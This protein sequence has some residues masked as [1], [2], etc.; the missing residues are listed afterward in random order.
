MGHGRVQNL[1]HWAQSCAGLKPGFGQAARY[2]RTSVTYFGDSRRTA[3][4]YP[5]SAGPAACPLPPRAGLRRLRPVPQQLR[6]LLPLL[7]DRARHPRARALW[8]TWQKLPGPG[9][10]RG[11]DR[12]GVDLSSA[13]VDGEPVRVRGDGARDGDAF[14]CFDGPGAEG[15]RAEGAGGGASEAVGSGGTLRVSGGW[16]LSR[17]WTGASVVT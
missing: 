3:D 14:A 6:G 5:S 7:Q 1:A 9:A 13:A 4:V 11:G 15:R 12:S 10:R 17:S 8:D 16:G 2:C